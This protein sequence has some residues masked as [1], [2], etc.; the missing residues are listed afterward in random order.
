MTTPLRTIL[1]SR[2][3]LSGLRDAMFRQVSSIDDQSMSLLNHPNIHLVETWI[4]NTSLVLL[5]AASTMLV[6]NNKKI[7]PWKQ[8]SR[9]E[10]TVKAIVI[11]LI[12]VLAKNVESVH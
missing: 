9:T 11:A 8:F 7:R 2:G 1:T 3:I 5:L 4:L 6:S 12:C 10:M